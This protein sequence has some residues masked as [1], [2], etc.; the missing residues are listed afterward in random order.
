MATNRSTVTRGVNIRHQRLVD[1]TSKQGPKV[2][3]ING[4]DGWVSGLQDFQPS[5]Y[6]QSRTLLIFIF[7]QWYSP[8]YDL[9]YHKPNIGLWYSCYLRE[10][11]IKSL[12]PELSS[13][14][15][16][17]PSSFSSIDVFLCFCRLLEGRDAYRLSPLPKRFKWRTTS[18]QPK[19]FKL[20]CLG[21]YWKFFYTKILALIWVNNEIDINFSN[22]YCVTTD[23]SAL[24]LAD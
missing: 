22:L 11:E 7:P 5:M 9:E 21:S 6:F 1:I 3:T 23:F 12:L 8:N 10:Y 4:L 18:S 13:R 20:R 15:F 24:Y 19:Y 2:W 17:V 14:I 16:A